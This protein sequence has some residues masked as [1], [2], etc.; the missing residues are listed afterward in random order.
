ML[1]AAV[2]AMR[3]VLN[4]IQMEGIIVIGE[5][6]KDEVRC[7]LLGAL[8]KGGDAGLLRCARAGVPFLFWLWLLVM[9][10]STGFSE[11]GLGGPP[12][13]QPFRSLGP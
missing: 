7:A 6:E 13:T 4:S 10:N 8:S 1:Q 3:K 2:D 9:L 5:G 12:R 11:S